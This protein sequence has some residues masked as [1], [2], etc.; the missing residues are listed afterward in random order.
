M[1]S[2]DFC[3]YVFGVDSGSLSLHFF[4][5][6]SVQLVHPIRSLSSQMN[7]RLICFSD[8]FVST[9][10]MRVHDCL[11]FLPRTVVGKIL[12]EIGL[13]LNCER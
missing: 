13:A 2:D 12:I 4:Q 9:L 5:Y 1:V 3:D 11:L 6:L 7:L 10:A 8:H